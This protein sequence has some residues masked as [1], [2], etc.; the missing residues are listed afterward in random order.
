MPGEAGEK[1]HAH[2]RAEADDEHRQRPVT[3]QLSCGWPVRGLRPL[4]ADVTDRLLNECWAEVEELV[5]ADGAVLRPSK[6]TYQLPGAPA[7]QGGTGVI[8]AVVLRLRRNTPSS[9]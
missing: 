1:E 9:P 6:L 5:P 2:Q 8:V 4:A 3:V 7:L